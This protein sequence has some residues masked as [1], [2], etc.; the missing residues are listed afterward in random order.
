MDVASPALSG[1]RTPRRAANPCG[2]KILCG[3][4]LEA[5]DR[6]AQLAPGSWINSSEICSSTEQKRAREQRHAMDPH[7][8]DRTINRSHASLFGVD[9]FTQLASRPLTVGPGNLDSRSANTISTAS[10]IWIFLESGKAERSRPDGGN[11]LSHITGIPNISPEQ[12]QRRHG[13][14]ERQPNVR[15]VIETSSECRIVLSIR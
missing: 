4:G 8:V 5:P 2:Q 6:S 14:I 7:R 15:G 3:A 1:Y 13:R 11:R 12:W 9:S 10:A